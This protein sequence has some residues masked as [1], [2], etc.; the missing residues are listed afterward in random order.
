MRKKWNALRAKYLLLLGHSSWS[1]LLRAALAVGLVAPLI[2]IVISKGMKYRAEEK[3]ALLEEEEQF[4]TA[5]DKVYADAQIGQ[6]EMA[7]G[8]MIE[9]GKRARTRREILKWKITMG[10]LYFLKIRNGI[11]NQLVNSHLAE[12]FFNEAFTYCKTAEERNRVDV[13]LGELLLKEKKYLFAS[14]HLNRID[15][16]IMKREEL[17]QVD[18][19]R[20]RCDW[21]LGSYQRALDLANV[22]ANTAENRDLWAEALL[23]ASEWML[24]VSK[25]KR[26]QDILSKTKLSPVKPDEVKLE[27]EKNFRLLIA[28]TDPFSE[29]N[30]RARLGLI[31]ILILNGKLNEAYDVANTILTELAKDKFK[32]ACLELLADAEEVQHHEKKLLEILEYGHSHFFNYRGINPLT[33]RYYRK[34]KELGQYAKAFEVA[35][36][37]VK[38]AADTVLIR[39]ILEDFHPGH[40]AF[41]DKLDWGDRQKRY[42]ERTRYLLDMVSEGEQ[43]EFQELREL[44]GF[45]RSAIPIA[46]KRYDEA[47]EKIGQFL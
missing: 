15:R 18:L 36:G 23:Q 20:A 31:K 17:W 27:A 42:Y 37:V 28:N 39:Q 24:E 25:S 6:M 3:A 22:V 34:L 26:L 38:K 5:V 43:R 19:W 35:V 9:L 7:L 30:G 46:A 1:M 2:G 8:L 32:L 41:F 12:K 44:A 10:R 45:L 13:L 14:R 21:A 40:G 4:F 33:R 11:G 47:D 16:S 29:Y